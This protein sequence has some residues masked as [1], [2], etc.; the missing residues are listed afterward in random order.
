MWN[1]GDIAVFDFDDC[2]IGLPVQDLATAL[3]YLDTPAEREIVLEGYRSIR[4]LPEYSDFQ[5][6][7]LLLQR[8]ILL[9]NYLYETA[10]EEHRE[11]IPTYLPE[12]MRRAKL[13]LR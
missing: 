6:Q 10:N 1:M 13:F 4:A 7:A 5:M 8:R 2:G 11:L 3:Y 12:T 9:L